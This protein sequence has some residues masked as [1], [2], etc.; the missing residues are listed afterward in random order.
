MS[1]LLLLAILALGLQAQDYVYTKPTSKVFIYSSTSKMYE[2]S[3][4]QQPLTPVTP[5]M[6]QDEQWVPVEYHDYNPRIDDDGLLRIEGN[7][8]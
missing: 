5:R 4:P 2:A 6:P 3:Q 8:Y 1:K 7:D